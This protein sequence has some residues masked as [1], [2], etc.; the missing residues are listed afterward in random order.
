MQQSD[1][2]EGEEADGA[3]RRAALES[4]ADLAWGG[5][6]LR[7]SMQQQLQHRVRNILSVVRSLAA[8]TVET[9][10]SLDDFAINFDGRLAA[11][12]RT[13]NMLSRRPDAVVELG[14]LLRDELLA[15]GAH[16][17]EQADLDGPV[18][19][20][21]QP[22]AEVMALAL[23]ELTVNALKFGALAHP[24]GRLSVTCTVRGAEGAARLDLRW[25]ETGAPVVDLSP[26]RSGFGRR[27][28][29]EALPYELDAETRLAFRPGGVQAD[30]T[31]PLGAA[32]ALPRPDLAAAANGRRKHKRGE[33]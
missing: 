31:I 13:Q 9:S 14:E 28:I 26:S 4:G 16:D 21:E 29:E 12:A 19:Y 20:L 1:G 17:G 25:R 27:M 7:R 2:E 32:M 30:I 23:H 11:L 24:E 5:A 6:D 3:G 18:V 8:R 15:A 22:A 33:D 10:E